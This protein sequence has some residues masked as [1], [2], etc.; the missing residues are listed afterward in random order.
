M[1]EAEAFLDIKF[2]LRSISVP[3]VTES[4]SA[5]VLDTM[6]LKTKPYL[7]LASSPIQAATSGLKMKSSYLTA[8]TALKTFSAQL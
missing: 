1:S 4:R 7:S 6:T 8:F 2:W 3:K 5:E